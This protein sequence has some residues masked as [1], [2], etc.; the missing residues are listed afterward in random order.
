MTVLRERLTAERER[1]SFIEVKRSLRSVPEGQ[2]EAHS[3]DPSHLRPPAEAARVRAGPNPPTGPA[4][5]RSSAVART[6]C[7]FGSF[8]VGRLP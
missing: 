2:H 4:P 3:D 1:R 7:R 6:Q 8:S 5:I